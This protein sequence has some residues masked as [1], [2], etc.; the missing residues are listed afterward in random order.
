MINFILIISFATTFASII[1]ANTPNSSPQPS[2]IT[3]KNGP[4]CPDTVI[5]N[6]TDEWN[7]QDKKTYDGALTRCAELWSDAPC[8]KLFKK[9]EKNLYNAI[10]GYPQ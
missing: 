8:L 3:P 7:E 4:K 9:K 6:L 10:C 5:I 1:A 2:L